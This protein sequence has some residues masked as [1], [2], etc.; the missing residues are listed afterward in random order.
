MYP[1]GISVDISDVGANDSPGDIFSTALT[2]L[3]NSV[4]HIKS[5]CTGEA[6]LLSVEF[7]VQF[8]QAVEVDVVTD[9][10]PFLRQVT[11][12]IFCGDRSCRVVLFEQRYTTHFH[13]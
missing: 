11:I 12:D 9:Q 5:E 6:R 3:P 8:A 4:V 13:F 7:K 10:G 2:L 1:S